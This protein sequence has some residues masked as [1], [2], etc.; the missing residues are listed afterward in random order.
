MEYPFWDVDIGYG[1][2][3]AG[4]A[5]I[6]VFISH[7]A[8]GGGLYLVVTERAARQAG[9][10]DRLAF[11]E[12]LSRFFV[13][14]SVVSGALTGVGI[15][16]II[17]LLNPEATGLLIHNFVWGWAVEWTFFFI[18]IAAALLYYY[19][20]RRMAARDHMVLGWIYFAAAWL[21]LAVI[22]G[23]IC[24]ML[25][26]GQWLQ[27]GD[28]WDGF[29][30]PTYWPSLFL[31]SAICAMLAGVY[32]LVVAARLSPEAGRDRIVR[33]NARWSLAGLLVSLPCFWWYWQAIPDDVTQTAVEA[34][35]VVLWFEVGVWFAGLL[36]MLSLLALLVPRRHTLT[37]AVLGMIAALGLFGSF[38]F[39]REV[40]RKPWAVVD[41]MYGN[42]VEVERADEHRRDGYLA[43]IEYRTG[44]DE[45]DLLNH[46]CRHCHTV[47]GYRSLAPIFAGTDTAFIAGVIKGLGNLRG[48]MP[49]FYGTDEERA[50]VAAAIHARVD[51]RS[52]A[53]DAGLSGQALGAQVL[54]VRCGVCHWPGSPADIDDALEGFTREDAEDLLDEAGDIAEEMP[55]FT[56]D[57]VERESLVLHLSRTEGEGD[58]S[59]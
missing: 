14:V 12:R 55:A 4:I 46:A 11:V 44:D 5:V 41:T 31:R 28:F 38:E 56:G 45:T 21:S 32:A 9:D 40:L 17:G 15:W 3:M 50:A 35:P 25:T 29:F 57:A 58:G 20:W 18:E 47:D 30:N 37:G 43:A 48:N 53:E 59:R 1:L 49:P 54:R 22:N 42:G 39:V 8:I 2:L 13:L 19:G 7:F 52:V 24:F 33:D 27:T 36:L 26:P 34:L 16:F 51:S 10:E 23:I 6:H